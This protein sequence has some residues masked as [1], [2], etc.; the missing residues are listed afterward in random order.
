MQRPEGV[1]ERSVG[2]GAVSSMAGP[3]GS[4]RSRGV[5]ETTTDYVRHPRPVTWLNA[6]GPVLERVGALPPLEVEAVMAAARR[7]TRLEDFGDEWFR[8]PLGVLLDS[9]K[10][11]AR[12]TPLGHWIQH[13]RIVGALVN[14]LRAEEMVR[15]SPEILDL[16]L[17][18]VVV[19]AG[20]Q[21][22]GTTLLHR[23]LS[24]DPEMRSLAAWEAISPVP[25]PGERAGQPIGRV[26]RA[27]FAARALAYLA[28]QFFA[29]H[30]ADHDAPEEDVLL[31]D[32]SFMSQAPEATLHVP[33]YAKWL[34]GGDHTRA[35][36]Y[37]RRAMQILLAQRG[38]R[39]WVL[40]SPNHLEHLDV[41]L[42]VFPEARIVQTHRDPQK[43]M[44]SFCSMVAH[45]RGLFSDDV[46][47]HEVARHWVR[48]VDRLLERSSRVRTDRGHGRFLDVS[49]YDLAA[50]PI[51]EAERVYDFAGL[52]L[53]NVARQAMTAAR[54]HNVQHKHGRHRYSL[55]DFGLCEEDIERAFGDYRTRFSI[56]FES[57]AGDPI[58]SP[59]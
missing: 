3:G 47:P 43:T 42:D 34:E 44:P 17:G 30:P 37:L 13:A 58:H 53:G 56:P 59:G 21:R 46:D 40:K 12:L 54:E 24:A 32:L 57:G 55:G 51:A 10:R 41:V 7:K 2:A 1:E 27:R 50:D 6:L 8:E 26:R 4:A 52:T 31:L 48:K 33:S 38:G 18:P 29:I 28:P 25:W 22:T 35:Y 9:L 11:E 15:R 16:E 36:Q 5:F 20:L 19:I 14:R 39:R 45:A 23:L 49:Y